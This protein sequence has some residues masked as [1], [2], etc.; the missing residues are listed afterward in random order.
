MDLANAVFLASLDRKVEGFLPLL[1][2]H[3][4]PCSSVC[5]SHWIDSFTQSSC[6][7]LSKGHI[8]CQESSLWLWDLQGGFSH[9]FLPLT[10]FSLSAQLCTPTCTTDT[11]GKSPWNPN[12]GWSRSSLGNDSHLPALPGAGYWKQAAYKMEANKHDS[13]LWK[14]WPI[15]QIPYPL[16]PVTCPCVTVPWIPAHHP[17]GQTTP[18]RPAQ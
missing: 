1:P 3:A 9:C 7:L 15:L 6:R 14:E 2:S 17:F 10:P 8:S 11:Q 5:P 4:F 13:T 18:K 16:W 12:A